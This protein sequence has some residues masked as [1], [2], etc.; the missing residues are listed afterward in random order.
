M[1]PLPSQWL[2][3]VLMEIGPVEAAG[4]DRAPISWREICAW[5]ELTATAL[6]PWQAKLLR[7]LSTEF[8]GESRRAEQPDCPAPWGAM[9]QERRDAVERKLHGIFGKFVR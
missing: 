8:L 7:W 6:E 2:I 1:P 4:M 3:D 9:T 5:Q